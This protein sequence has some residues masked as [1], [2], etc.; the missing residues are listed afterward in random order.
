MMGIFSRGGGEIERQRASPKAQYLTRIA[1]TI[2]RQRAA[3]RRRV[4]RRVERQLAYRL[5]PGMARQAAVIRRVD[6]AF[7]SVT[8]QGPR[9]NY[10]DRLLAEN[11]RKTWT[12][13]TALDPRRARKAL[14]ARIRAAGGSERDVRRA[15]KALRRHVKNL[16]KF[17][18]I[19]SR[20]LGLS[21]QASR[22]WTQ[23]VER[24][25]RW[26]QKRRAERARSDAKT[27]SRPAFLKFRQ[28]QPSLPDGAGRQAVGPAASRVQARQ[29]PAR[30]P[31]RVARPAPVPRG[32]PRQPRSEPARARPPE[33]ER[34]KSF[35]E[36]KQAREFVRGWDPSSVADR[37]RTQYHKAVAR[38]GGLAAARPE[39]RAGTYRSF[40]YQRAA[41]VF[42][43]R[44][45]LKEALRERDRAARAKDQQA[46][47]QA[48]K[49]IHEALAVLTR[50]PPSAGD[51]SANAGRENPFRKSDLGSRHRNG[52][53][54]SLDHLPRDWRERIWNEIPARDRDAVAV[55]ALAGARPAE[56]KKGVQVVRE[57]QDLVIRIR[58]AKLDEKRGKG[59]ALREVRVDL[60]DVAD[61]VEG[62]HLLGRVGGRGKTV[63]I[64]GRPDAFT[65]RVR[66][67]SRRAMPEARTATVSPYTYRHAFAARL[68]AQQL[69]A[70]AR[71]AALGHQQERSGWHYGHA[72]Q[73]A[74]AGRG[75]IKSA[76]A[77]R[78]VRPARGRA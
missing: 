61:S 44:A 78:A 15:D 11:G 59:Q 52:K 41:L 56:L 67:A 46:Q 40:L 53:R 7:K 17:G 14:A 62:R 33:A 1:E 64:E 49:R 68:K 10:F 4:V 76:R 19:Q 43:A 77:T 5:A 30:L 38:L 2:E 36:I 21:Q 9:A 37:T 66:A 42:V 27:A 12:G 26:I 31:A 22:R 32:T 72:S 69:D 28:R 34:S 63:R 23:S 39:E 29:Q 55:A 16:K 6:R 54:A 50:Y 25:E 18:V 70:Q 35:E 20:F 13:K 73:A 3:E 48:E 51:R 58:G 8:G 74:S 45:Q 75:G 24:T 57:G 71:A 65:H 60:R 47:S